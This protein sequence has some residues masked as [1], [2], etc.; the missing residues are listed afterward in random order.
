MDVKDK[1]QAQNLIKISKIR[2]MMS[3][4]IPLGMSIIIYLIGG[5]NL[6][7]VSLGVKKFILKSI[8]RQIILNSH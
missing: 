8:G 3:P 6:F 4:L 1:D 5:W 2:G 7:S